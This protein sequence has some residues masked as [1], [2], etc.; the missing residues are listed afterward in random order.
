M[1]TREYI[2]Q[3]MIRLFEDE[4][5]EEKEYTD[6]KYWLKEHPEDQEYFTDLYKSYVNIESDRCVTD[7]LIQQ[8]WQNFTQDVIKA[9]S[10][11]KTSK[12]IQWKSIS[13]YAA[14]FVLGVLLSSSVM[15]GYQNY[16]SQRLFSQ[17]IEVPFGGKSNIYLAD[18]TEVLLNAGSQLKY[19]ASFGQKKR[20]VIIEGE[21]YFKVAKG[22]LFDVKT[23]QGII[24]VVGTQF[25]VKQ[26]DNYFEVI[27]F[28]GIVKVSS[29]NIT[30]QL[31]A[32]ETFQILNGKFTESKT[33]ASSPKWLENMS[34]FK[35]IPFEEVL[36]E[37][38][39]QYDV[40]ITIKG[41]DINRLFTGGF[42]HNNLE[43][44]LKAITQPMNMTYNLNSSNLVIIHEAKN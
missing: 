35:A 21:A 40:Q 7:Q 37:L 17:V 28:E 4:Q 23:K 24:T 6:V 38:E 1:V 13:R 43:N 10:P 18:G 15:W 29:N 14:I 33:T 11:V 30:K 5:L 9:K 32:G 31:V 19:N 39:R 26:R 22:K 3:L 36:A 16:V 42:M 41:A 34:E 27:C 25:N 2:Y 20:E 8:Q 12:L 44:A